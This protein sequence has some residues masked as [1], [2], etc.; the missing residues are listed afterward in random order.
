[1]IVRFT[2]RLSL[3]VVLSLMIGWVPGLHSS[4]RQT[5]GSNQRM[6][7]PSVAEGSS[8][9]SYSQENIFTPVSQGFGGFR[10]N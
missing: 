3:L 7:G 1:M 2:K 9:P 6:L 4:V 10:F 5:G 8:E